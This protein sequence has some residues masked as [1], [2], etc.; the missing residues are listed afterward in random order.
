M[1]A[2]GPDRPAAVDEGELGGLTDGRAVT[3]DHREGAG[4]LGLGGLDCIDN[5]AGG[6]RV[7]DRHDERALGDEERDVAANL[8]PTST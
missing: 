1:E 4:A 8:P 3:L 7:R 2:Q 5:L 6:P